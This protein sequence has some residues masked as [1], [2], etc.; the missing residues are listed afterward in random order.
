MKQMWFLRGVGKKLN[1]EPYTGV[2][3]N[4]Y[5]YKIKEEIS[6]EELIR[7]V[8]DILY[9]FKENGAILDRFEL[10]ESE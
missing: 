2:F 1:G 4:L 6:S 9:M 7:G 8:N 3:R 10:E 5:P